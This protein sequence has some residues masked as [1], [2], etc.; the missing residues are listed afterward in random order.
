MPQWPPTLTTVICM[1]SFLI[2]WLCLSTWAIGRDIILWPT[3]HFVS[4]AW[5]A[6]RL[7]L[8]VFVWIHQTDSYGSSQMDRPVHQFPYTC[9]L[10]LELLQLSLGLLYPAQMLLIRHLP[11]LQ[12]V[13]S[14]FT[15][16][17]FN[18]FESWMMMRKKLGNLM[19]TLVAVMPQS[20][21]Q[22]KSQTILTWHT[23]FLEELSSLIFKSQ[24]SLNIRWWIHAPANKVIRLNKRKDKNFRGELLFRKASNWIKAT[25][26]HM[27]RQLAWADLQTG[28]S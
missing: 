6:V 16:R 7:D 20:L 19:N 26:Y 11:I 4:L 25:P 8:L 9:H 21:N 14:I 10:V 23:H 22:I 28:D 13:I 27:S 5:R 12:T 17:I 1:T 2:Y 15:H 18:G 3:Y 24:R